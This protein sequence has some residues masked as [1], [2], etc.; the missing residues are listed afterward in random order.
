MPKRLELLK[1]A[2]PALTNIGYLANPHYGL[3]KPQLQEMEAAA[4]R[5]GVV[6]SLVEVTTAD[7][8]ATAFVQLRAKGAQA[9]V[10]QQDPLFTGEDKRVVAFAEAYGLPAIYPLR[11]FYDAGGLMWL[12]ADVGSQF[13]RAATYVD[14]ILRGAQPAE[15]PIERPDRLYLTVNMK[16]ARRL[17]IDINPSVLARADEVIE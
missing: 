14:K 2:L 10:V 11:G 16:L 8:L 17:G 4:Q 1:E 9:F 13:H 12:G 3:H 5:L 6:L 15:L 7:E